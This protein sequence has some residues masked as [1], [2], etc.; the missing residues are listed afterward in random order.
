MV[1]FLLG[2]VG[3]L[4]MGLQQSLK[5]RRR[6]HPARSESGGLRSI[7]ISEEAAK[8]WVGFTPVLR[9]GNGVRLIYF[10]RGGP[11]K[12][13]KRTAFGEIVAPVA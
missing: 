10:E 2:G 6:I 13:P 3:A 12:K 4:L 1:S 11:A 7:A 9:P 5:V 8:K